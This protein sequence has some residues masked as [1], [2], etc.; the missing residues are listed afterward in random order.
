M[1]YVIAG[2]AIAGAATSY[3]ASQEQTG[4][5]NNQ[6]HAN[7]LN[8]EHQARLKVQQQNDQ[9][10]QNMRQQ[11]LQ[12]LYI[13]KAA[14]S[15]KIRNKRSLNR[16]AAQQ[17]T[18]M[19][20]SNESAYDLLNSSIGAKG[21]SGTSGTA[22]AMKR[23]AFRNWARS[24]ESLKYNTN[25]QFQALDDQYQ[26]SLARMGKNEYLLNSYIGGQA[27]QPINGGWSAIAA[28]V[29]GGT[30]GAMAGSQLTS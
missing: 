1:G 3:M 25:E 5:A 27:P 21:I 19:N 26:G 22:L 9:Q 15:T 14:T 13:G 12:N 28:G 8:Q 29:S 18:A 30:S 4:N 24:A 17:F 23:Q 2:L 16:V 20:Q 7:Y 6:A 10:I 11:T